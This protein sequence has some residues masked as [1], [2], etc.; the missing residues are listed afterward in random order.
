MV[1]YLLK[2]SNEFLF[3]VCIFSNLFNPFSK[4]GHGGSDGLHGY[5]HSLDYAVDDLV[6]FDLYPQD[7]DGFIL[8]PMN[9]NALYSCPTLYRNHFLTRS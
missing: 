6:C 4:P 9:L 2:I 8:H 7:A 5:V 3:L 1:Q